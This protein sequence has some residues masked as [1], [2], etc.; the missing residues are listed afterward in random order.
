VFDAFF[1]VYMKYA[2]ELFRIYRAGGSARDDDLPAPLAELLAGHASQ[3]ARFFFQLCA[4][5]LDYCPP[6]DLTFGDFL[7]AL[8]T[9]AKDIDPADDRGIRDA[10][11]EAFRLRGIYSESASFFSE[12]AL[13]WPRIPKG[14]LTPI[15]GLIFGSPN[16]LTS[17]Q[18]DHNGDVL[19]AWARKHRPQLGLDPKLAV[20]VPSFH[21]VFRTMDNGRLRVEMVVEIIQT[22]PA[23]FDPDV[24]EVGSFPFRGGV[25][26]IVEAPEMTVDDAGRTVELPPEVRFAIAKTLTGAEGRRREAT[27]RGL[28]MALGMAE[29]NI[30]DPNHF[31][32]N[33]GLLHEES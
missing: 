6:V 8:I 16:G 11:M 26:V 12:D 15:V 9:V 25:T 18:K 14:T 30:E 4:R 5:A 29:G 1:S 27:Q 24:P 33:F 17:A 3:T 7:R 10:L 20:G 23:A 32:A 31:Q 2:N 28:A 13:C 19:R 21:P 22:R